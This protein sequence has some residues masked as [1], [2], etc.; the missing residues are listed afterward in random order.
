MRC[1]N[2]YFFNNKIRGYR[3]FLLIDS[4]KTS[5]VLQCDVWYR[6][7]L[8]SSQIY[9]NVIVLWHK[10]FLNDLFSQ[11]N[12]IGIK[13]RYDQYMN[14][15]R[16]WISEKV[17][18]PKCDWSFNQRRLFHHERIGLIGSTLTINTRSVSILQ[19]W[20]SLIQKPQ[21]HNYCNRSEIIGSLMIIYFLGSCL[22]Q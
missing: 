2:F 18:I 4:A 15:D 1:L 12:H 11:W 19:Y 6:N 10:I 20:K 7:I 8:R 22:T 16:I 5:D 17:L 14:S 3:I 13:I 21:A 9:T